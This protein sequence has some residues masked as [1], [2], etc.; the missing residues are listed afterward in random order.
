M[1]AGVHLGL[2]ISVRIRQSP[3]EQW[4]GLAFIW[5]SS[6]FYVRN[7]TDTNTSL[8]W[9]AE[10]HS[11]YCCYCGDSLH[12]VNNRQ[13]HIYCI[14]MNGPLEAFWQELGNQPMCVWCVSSRSHVNHKTQAINSREWD[15]I[16]FDT[17]SVKADWIG[18]PLQHHFK[19][20]RVHLSTR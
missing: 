18:S 10:L 14:Y 20:R 15:V 16:Y 8:R 6:C 17:F 13:R 1:L 11:R 3:R 2:H 5:Q 12:L 19:T 7:P 4:P 9:S